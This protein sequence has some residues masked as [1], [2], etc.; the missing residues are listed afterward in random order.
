MVPLSQ[1]NSWN[2]TCNYFGSSSF[3]YENACL[4]FLLEKTRTK[5][6]HKATYT[7]VHAHVLSD[8]LV[9]YL[10]YAFVKNRNTICTDTCLTI[11]FK[12]HVILC[13]T[14]QLNVY[15]SMCVYACTGC[16]VD[17]VATFSRECIFKM[18][19]DLF[20]EFDTVQKMSNDTKNFVV[21][22]KISFTY[23]LSE[24]LRLYR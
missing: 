19:V 14:D 9:S 20:G 7:Y 24:F 5:L 4:F 8:Y 23:Q 15:V 21:D 16:S 13:I 18:A 22:I 10:S 3:Y 2:G 6:L 11:L 1:L 12:L 17:S